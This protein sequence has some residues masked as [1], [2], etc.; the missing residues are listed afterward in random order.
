MLKL[1]NWQATNIGTHK[2]VKKNNN[3]SSKFWLGFRCNYFHILGTTWAEYLQSQLFWLI[4][5]TKTSST[6]EISA[7]NG[8]VLIV[9]KIQS[10]CGVSRVSTSFHWSRVSS[11]VWRWAMGWMIRGSIPG[12]AGNFSLHHRIQNGSAPPP[13]PPIQ[14]VPGVLSRGVKRPVREADHSPPSSVRGKRM[15]GTI[16]PL[17]QYVFMAWCYVK[18]AQRQPYLC[19]YL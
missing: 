1:L 5:W 14:F 6:S 9:L 18:K 17:P 8:H 3:N 16:P 12:E 11:A 2:V 10:P 4:T 13:Q 19:F 15:S 7:V